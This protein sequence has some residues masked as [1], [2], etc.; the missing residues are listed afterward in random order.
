MKN[1]KRPTLKQKK[2]IISRGLNIENW[3]VVKDTMECI[4]II[5]RESKKLKRLY[6]SQ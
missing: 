5:N 4:E 3:L 6:K 2:M 1:G